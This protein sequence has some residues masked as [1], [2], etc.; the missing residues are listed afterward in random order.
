LEKPEIG[1]VGTQLLD[2]GVAGKKAA[3]TLNRQ[4]IGSPGL[5]S[6]DRKPTGV[7]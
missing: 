1:P 3:V 6:A 4:S 2:F 7:C 5:G